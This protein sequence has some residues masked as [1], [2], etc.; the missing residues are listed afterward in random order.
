[1]EWINSIQSVPFEQAL[2]G[3]AAGLVLVAFLAVLLLRARSKRSASD[4]A[5]NQRKQAGPSGSSHKPPAQAAPLQPMRPPD[6]VAD[7]NRGIEAWRHPSGRAPQG[8]ITNGT[9]QLTTNEAA[10]SCAFLPAHP[11]KTYSV[12]Y[13]AAAVAEPTNGASN[14][15]FVGPMFLDATGKVLVWFR[16]QPPISLAEGERKGIVEI[17]APTDAVT[18]HIGM[19]GNYTRDGPSGDGSI[20][21][22]ELRLRE[23]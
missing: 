14:N 18:V 3:G 16:E 5:P 8:L 1:M 13:R 4:V 19:Q 11:G 21:I 6:L 15:F 10:L 12:Q 22:L 2:L 9:Y 7:F 23:K 17:E 20:A